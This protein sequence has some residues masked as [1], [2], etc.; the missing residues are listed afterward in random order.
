[1]ANYIKEEVLKDE[2]APMEDMTLEVTIP[3]SSSAGD[4][5]T[6]ECPNKSYV[7]FVTPE[8]VVAGDTVHVVVNESGQNELVTEKE[9]STT[10]YQGVAA[11]T[12]VI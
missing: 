2:E 12:T 7:Q 10:S 11:V 8:N 9:S 6:I 3:E 1:M 4:K 5:I